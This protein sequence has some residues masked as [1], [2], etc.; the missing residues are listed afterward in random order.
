MG[1]ISPKSFVSLALSSAGT[2]LITWSIPRRVPISGA[3][4]VVRSGRAT[5]WATA[6]RAKA[7]AGAARETAAIVTRREPFGGSRDTPACDI[8]V[9]TPSLR[10]VLVAGDAGSMPILALEG[11]VGRL[12]SDIVT[13]GANLEHFGLG[14]AKAAVLS[15]AIGALVVRASQEGTRRAAAIIRGGRESAREVVRRDNCLGVDVSGEGCKSCFLLDPCSLSPT[16][17]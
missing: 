16:I 7:A 1:L 2:L 5:A 12:E 15:V 6:L 9:A 3:T 14:M 11:G 17:L 8:L 13:F 10:S 4:T